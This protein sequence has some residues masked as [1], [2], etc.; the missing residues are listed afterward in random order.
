MIPDD[1]ERVT[2]V[3]GRKLFA[4]VESPI[5]YTV[6]RIWQGYSSQFTTMRERI[7]TYIRYNV[8]FVVIGNSFRN[9]NSS[10]IIICVPCYS[11]CLVLLGEYIVVYAVN[12]KV[13]GVDNI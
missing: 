11:T 8:F 3:N 9:I 2:E 12:F 1:C 6:N 7:I 4:V 10:F 5:A 13:V